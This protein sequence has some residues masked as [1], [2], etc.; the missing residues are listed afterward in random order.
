MTAKYLKMLDYDLISNGFF[1]FEIDTQASYFRL[2]SNVQGVMFPG[3]S[4][5][6]NGLPIKVAMRAP[7]K[8]FFGLTGE[9]LGYFVPSDEFWKGRNNNYEELVSLEDH[10]ADST[11]DRMIQAVMEGN[12]NF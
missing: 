10:V 7:F 2:G 6:R 3:E 12:R 8:F 9:T 11:R 4:L 1:N 5:T